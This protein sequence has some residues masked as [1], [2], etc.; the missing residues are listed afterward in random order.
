MEQHTARAAQQDA[1]IS[2][3]SLFEQN[4]E[5]EITFRGVTA[6][7]ETLVKLCPVDLSE[8]SPEAIEEYTR[9]ILVESGV[10]VEIIDQV[11]K[12]KLNGLNR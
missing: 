10:E 11:A 1:D 6:T 9:K 8:K 12:K 5:R 7:L 4:R 2:E 3:A